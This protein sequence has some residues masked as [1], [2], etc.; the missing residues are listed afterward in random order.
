[1]I[2]NKTKSDIMNALDNHK[3]FSATDFRIRIK[4]QTINIKYDFEPKFYFNLSLPVRTSSKTLKTTKPPGILGTREYEVEKEVEVYIINAKICPGEM[5]L[6]EN[7][8]FEGKTQIANEIYKWLN[9]IWEEMQSIPINKLVEEQNK[10]IEEIKLKVDG[11][12]EE[13]FTIEEGEDLKTK[14]DSLEDLLKEKI[15]EQSEKNENLAKKL[16]ELEEQIDILRDTIFILNKK[17]WFKS[18]MTKMYKW[19]SKEDNRKLLKDG[20]KLL[21]PLLPESVNNILD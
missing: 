13:Y 20:V 6:V 7:I 11:I 19:I 12:S 2:R 21:K 10:I 8:K 17:N 4:N 18:S 9:S 5:V 15:E 1:M 3:Y 14:L 16:K